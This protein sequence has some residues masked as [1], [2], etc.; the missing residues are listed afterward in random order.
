MRPAEDFASAPNHIEPSPEPFSALGVP[1]KPVA[2]QAA[3]AL[4]PRAKRSYRCFQ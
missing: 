1:R 2:S 4:V 3:A